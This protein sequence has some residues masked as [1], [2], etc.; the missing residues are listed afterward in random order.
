MLLVFYSPFKTDLKFLFEI[1]GRKTAK[2]G[3]T[4]PFFIKKSAAKPKYFYMLRY[5]D[6]C[7]RRRRPYFLQNKIIPETQGVM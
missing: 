6:K 5:Y 2:K 3:I 4:V 1:F 7:P